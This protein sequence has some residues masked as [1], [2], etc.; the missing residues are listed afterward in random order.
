[1]RTF[2]S[3]SSLILFLTLAWQCNPMFS[4]REEQSKTEQTEDDHERVGD[5][6]MLEAD[7]TA[8]REQL[9]QVIASIDRK[10][11][12]SDRHSRESL[13]TLRERLERERRRIEEQLT[14]LR[15]STSDAW[16]RVSARS[17]E[18]LTDAKIEAQKVE[19]SIEN[20]L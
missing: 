20:L 11:K 12:S 9:N 3:L 10:I 19:E 16:D 5:R 6:R 18:I 13:N 14:E 4:Q 17:R 8:C 15:S 7:L 2:V 1:M